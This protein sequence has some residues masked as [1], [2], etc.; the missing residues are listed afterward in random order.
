VRK[1][2]CL[3]KII[4][5][6]RSSEDVRR[7]LEEAN[8]TEPGK[9]NM[10]TGLRHDAML[11]IHIVDAINLGTFQTTYVQLRQHEMQA[12]TK[13]GNGT[14]PIWNEGIVFDIKDE[15]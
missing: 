8:L 2:E 5:H 15:S 14:G 11:K 13:E 7:K 1:G 3:L 10:D 4:E 9:I 12:K 6:N